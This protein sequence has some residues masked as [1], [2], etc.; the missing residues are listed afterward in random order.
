MACKMFVFGP[1]VSYSNIICEL[2]KSDQL[3]SFVV[4]GHAAW[5]LTIQSEF[6]LQTC[7]C[8]FCFSFSFFIAI[9]SHRNPSLVEAECVHRAGHVVRNDGSCCM[10]QWPWAP[11]RGHE[12]PFSERSSTASFRIG[13]DPWPPS[14]W[15]LGLGLGDIGRDFWGLL[16]IS[17]SEI[18]SHWGAFIGVY[19]L[20]TMSFEV[21]TSDQSLTGMQRF[22]VC[23]EFVAGCGLL[24][25]RTDIFTLAMW[26]ACL[27]H[28]LRM[29]LGLQWDG[30]ASWALVFALSETLNDCGHAC[31]SHTSQNWVS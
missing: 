16:E 21:M 20:L 8:N 17:K 30:K 24:W 5:L 19:T 11:A 14:V 2:Y 10:R 3:V 7:R 15:S 22:W 23:V 26:I 4:L 27:R 25:R 9:H 13:P 12:P 29:M 28:T 1:S 6:N 31:V 18:L